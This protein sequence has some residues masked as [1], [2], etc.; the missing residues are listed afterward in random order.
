MRRGMYMDNWYNSL[1]NRLKSSSIR[2]VYWMIANRDTLVSKRREEEFYRRFLV[3]LKR[4]DM[5]FD[6]GANDGAKTDIFLRLGTNVVAIEPDGACQSMLRDR[7]LRY[8]WRSSSVALVGKAVSDKSGVEEMWVD[9]PGSAV[10]TMSRKWADHLKENKNSFRH[11][12]CGLEFGHS[13]SVE[14]ATIRDLV[15][16]YGSPFFI[17]IDVEG[18]ELRVLRGMSQPVPFLSFEINLSTF[19][20]E[21]IEC[22]R[23]LGRLGP[24]GRFNYTPDCCVGLALQDWLAPVEFCDVL[25][26]CTEETIEVFWRSNHGAVHNERI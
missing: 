2:R 26:S 6:V 12:H 15:K 5:V 8:R 19:R 16:L 20:Q 3:G 4:G 10:N 7:F 24:D 9:G 23:L 14:T 22:V 11:G 1:R 17:K 25:D 13:K 18:H 21:G